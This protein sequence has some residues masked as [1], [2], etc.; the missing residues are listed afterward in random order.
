MLQAEIEQRL[1]AIFR[2]VFEDD[3]LV[4]TPEMTADDVEDWDSLSHVRMI[5]TVEQEM[6]VKFAASEVTS[7][8]NFGDLVHL[9]EVK[10]NQS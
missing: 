8:K 10:T 1:S 6:K 3:E 7:L 2:D 4:P 5:L 9:I